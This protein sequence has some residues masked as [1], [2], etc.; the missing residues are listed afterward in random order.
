MVFLTDTFV[1]TEYFSRLT[2]S[3]IDVAG[4]GDV[5]QAFR[6]VY[7]QV[8]CEEAR[9]MGRRFERRTNRERYHNLLFR[10]SSIFFS[11]ASLTNTDLTHDKNNWN[12]TP[13]YTESETSA[14][15]RI[16]DPSLSKSSDKESG[17]LIDAWRYLHPD[18]EHYTYF[19]YRFNCRAKGIGWRLDMCK[20]CASALFLA[21]T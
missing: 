13:G 4:E 1:R 6:S 19:G 18:T 9:D 7:P 20:R 17:K 11:Q 5:E 10:Y 3:L 8:R 15:A 21:V 12:K 2:I 16:L 14:F